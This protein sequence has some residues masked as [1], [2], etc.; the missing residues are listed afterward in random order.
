MPSEQP[1]L[2]AWEHSVLDLPRGSSV[3]LSTAPKRA[4]R[5]TRARRPRNRLLEGVGGGDRRLGVDTGGHKQ[6]KEEGCH[7]RVCKSCV[8]RAELAD[9]P[10]SGAA[11]C[12]LKS[13]HGGT[14]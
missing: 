9:F 10:R 13:G 12:R 14:P 6:P 2:C 3:R 5:C 7:R 4:E 1:E 11:K 8:D